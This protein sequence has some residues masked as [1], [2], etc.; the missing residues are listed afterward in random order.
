MYNAYLECVTYIN[1]IRNKRKISNPSAQMNRSASITKDKRHHR[2]LPSVVLTYSQSHHHTA[3]ASPNPSHI[4]TYATYTNTYTK[5]RWFDMCVMHCYVW[6]RCKLAFVCSQNTLD[7]RR[8]YS[9]SESCWVQL[10]LKSGW[11][12][13][14]VR[15]VYIDDG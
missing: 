7:G 5:Y 14:D 10:E 1:Q 15:V 3:P 2:H 12:N 6:W 9:P 4:C 11:I 8:V 13:C